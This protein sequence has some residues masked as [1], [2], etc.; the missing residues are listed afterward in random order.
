MIRSKLLFLFILAIF[1]FQENVSAQETLLDKF[2]EYFKTDYFSAGILFQ[3]VFDYQGERTLPGQNGFSIANARLKLSGKL[4]KGFG[5]FIQTNFIKSSPLLDAFMSYKFS[6]QAKV[7]IGQFKAPFSLEELTSASAIDF[8]NRSNVVNNLAPKRQIGL[9]L[10]G[11]SN[12]KIISYQAG[13]FN[14]NKTIN[15]NND[16]KFLYAGRVGLNPIMN[17]KIDL[18]L[19][20]NAAYNNANENLE[21][22]KELLTGGDLR[23]NFYNFLLSGE[24]IYSSKKRFNNTIDAK[25]YYVTAGYNI[26]NKVQILLRWDDYLPYKILGDENRYIIIGCNVWPTEATEFQINYLINSN[27]SEF[28]HNQ[29]LFNAQIAI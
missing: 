6:E 13:I 29:V 1:L 25:G 2:K 16:K 18:M 7:K 14:G 21:N 10:S 3:S 28:N 22:G 4:D 19:G 26:I 17:N 11:N 9:E 5:Y 27:D 8:V 20:I 12:N 23:F 15:G 24:F